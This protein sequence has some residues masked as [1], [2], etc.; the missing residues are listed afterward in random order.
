[1]VAECASML[2][3]PLLLS[4]MPSILISV[5]SSLLKSTEEQT[6]EWRF[7]M[8]WTYIIKKEKTM[9]NFSN[10]KRMVIRTDLIYV[11]FNAYI[12][13][14]IDDLS[15]DSNMIYIEGN[16]PDQISQKMLRVI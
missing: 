10:I 12:W 3:P 8:S 6:S 11:L 16:K 5:W 13:L 2:Y 1:M 9:I 14:V 4:W 15:S 7:K